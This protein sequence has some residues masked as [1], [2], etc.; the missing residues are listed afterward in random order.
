[1]QRSDNTNAINTIEE[2]HARPFQPIMWLTRF[3][4]GRNWATKSFPRVNISFE[5][6]N[7]VL[8]ET[9]WKSE[10]H[11]PKAQKCMLKISD[12]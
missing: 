4:S 9:E 8:V 7:K 5:I 6:S 12:T 1:M 11:F 3:P 10:M 2:T